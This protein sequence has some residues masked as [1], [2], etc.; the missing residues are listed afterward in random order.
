MEARTAALALAVTQL[1]MLVTARHRA[2]P[3][4]IT[5]ELSEIDTH[6]LV[7]YNYYF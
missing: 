5:A 1:A 7:S 6:L 4:W 2:P 3:A